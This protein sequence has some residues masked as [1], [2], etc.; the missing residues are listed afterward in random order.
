MRIV[1]PD[2][3][4]N[5]AFAV[6][7]L[8]VS[9]AAMA[10]PVA[11]GQSTTT[12]DGPEF[13]MPAGELLA[14]RSIAF[15]LTVLEVPEGMTAEPDPG[16]PSA[17]PSTTGTLTTS[18]RRATDGTGLVFVYDLDLENDIG[19]A[20]ELARLTV[21][22]FAGFSTD[23]TGEIGEANGFEVSRSADGA[24]VRAEVGEGLG[25][26]VI[27][28]IETDAT[29]FDDGGSGEFSALAEYVLRDPNDPSFSDQVVLGATVT[30]DDGL[31]QPVADDGEPNP[32]PLPPAAWAGLATMGGF[33]AIRKL[34]RRRR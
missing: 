15:T 25:G 19:F 31:F 3:G 11:P 30:F 17:Q 5:V 6:A 20:D 12:R 21:G 29:E 16:E 2:A 22:S 8:A 33:G 9:S 32:I 34:R 28:A 23:A 13:Q 10:V 7:V 26:D 24:T 18:V 14:E 4:R 1:P 27:M